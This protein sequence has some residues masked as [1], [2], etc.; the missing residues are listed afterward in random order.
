LYLLIGSVFLGGSVFISSFISNF[1][2]FVVVFGIVFGTTIGC[3]YMPPFA[4]AYK[5]FP[6]NKGMVSGIVSSGFGFGAFVMSFISL[7][8]IN[9][10]GDNAAALGFHDKTFPKEVADNLPKML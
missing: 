6:R 7:A 8:V 9:P 1:Y 3:T 4:N 2:G 5:Y 10:D